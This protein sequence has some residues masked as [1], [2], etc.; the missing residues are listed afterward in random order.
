MWMIAFTQSAEMAHDR[1]CGNTRSARRIALRM[2]TYIASEAVWSFAPSADK[3]YVAAASRAHSNDLHLHPRRG[4]RVEVVVGVELAVHDAQ[5]HVGEER[6]QVLELT[7]VRLRGR[8]LRKTTI[9][10]SWRTEMHENTTV[11]S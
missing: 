9:T 4:Q 7:R 6:H 8:T 5:Q 2:A 3:I 10:K 11:T 1:W